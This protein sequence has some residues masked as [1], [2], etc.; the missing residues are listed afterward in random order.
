MKITIFCTGFFLGILTICS[1]FYIP[2]KLQIHKKIDTLQ[3]DSIQDS[4]KQEVDSVPIKLEQPEFFLEDKPNIA[5]LKEACKY[6]NIQHVDI[7]IA[8]A[9]LETGHFK[10]KQC[11]EKNNLFGLY[12]SVNRRYYSFNHWTE[13]VKAYYDLVQY[14]YKEGDY[15]TWLVKIRYASDP[16]YIN[17]VK[18]IQ[19]DNNL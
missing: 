2:N 11:R 17:K 4:I 9:L 7:V 5:A 19:K 13:S 18:Q 6:Y 16:K 15:Y 1:C 10:S 8:Q 14:R 12:D 3:Q